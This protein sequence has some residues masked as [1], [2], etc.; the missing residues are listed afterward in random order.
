MFHE[1]YEECAAEHDLDVECDWEKFVKIII[2]EELMN[3]RILTEFLWFFY[4][5]FV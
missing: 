2:F 3:W 4:E 5:I 1:S